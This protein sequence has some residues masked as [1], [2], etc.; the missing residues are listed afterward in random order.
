MVEREPGKETIGKG[1]LFFL[2]HP[3]TEEIFSGYGFDDA[4]R[5]QR[6]PGWTP[7]VDRPKPADPEWLKEVEV[8]FGECHLVAMTA[9]GERGIACQMQI[10]T[11]SLSLVAVDFRVHWVMGC[12]I[13]RRNTSSYVL[14]CFTVPWLIFTAGRPCTILT[15]PIS[16]PQPGQAGREPVGA[17]ETPTWSSLIS[18]R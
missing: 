9:T 13:H 2:W 8:T 3:G 10:E 7:M 6:S 1:E 15:M 4:G 5:K 18:S 17:P 12:S 14:V 11:E 16:L